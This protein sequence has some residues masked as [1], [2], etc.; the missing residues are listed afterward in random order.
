MAEAMKNRSTKQRARN[1]ADPLTAVDFFS[2]FNG[3]YSPNANDPLSGGGFFSHAAYPNPNGNSPPAKRARRRKTK[4]QH[5][6]LIELMRELQ[7]RSGMLPRQVRSAVKPLY[8]ERYPGRFH[9][10]PSHSAITRAYREYDGN[11]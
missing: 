10:D 11:D 4:T 1:I 3:M 8:K 6:R 2:D 7:L 9:D 5:D